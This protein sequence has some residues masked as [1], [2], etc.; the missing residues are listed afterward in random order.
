VTVGN[1]FFSPR[2]L[3]IEVGDT[4]RWTN[5][6][7][8]T[9]NVI[10]D[11]GAWRSETSSSFVFERTFNSVEEI[12]YYCSIH[13][14][15]NGSS[16]N[17]SISVI[18]ASGNEDPNA[19]FSF[20]CTGLTCVFT[21]Q[22]TD[23]DGT[24]VSRNWDFGDGGASTEANPSRSY[25]AGGT[26]SVKLTVMDNEGVSDDVS[27]DVTV[28]AANAAPTAAFSYSC[29][30]LDCDFTDQSMD[31]DGN[32]VAWSWSFGDSS[33][34][35]GARNP[36]HSYASAGT[37]AVSLRATDDDGDNDTTIQN[38]T[39]NS[40]LIN[41]GITDAWYFP[42]TG[43]QGF[44]IV[45]WEKISFMFLSWFTFDIGNPPAGMEDIPDKTIQR[46]LSARETDS[47]GN[48]LMAILGDDG[49]RWLTAQ[50]PYEG[51]TAMLEVFS[52][53]GGIFDTAPPE[54]VTEKTGT[55]KIQW[56]GC[57]SG[58]LTYDFP[59]LVLMGEILIERIV[60]D[61]VPMC[62]DAQAIQTD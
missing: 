41:P 10:E 44:F 12:E 4:V 32:I 39:V 37:Y 35:S 56:T 1:N 33:A 11:N 15:P 54:V 27:H 2:N 23:S 58:I 48:D 31:V 24:I 17:G 8:R 55:I 30:G 34:N 9:H 62:E 47:G 20:D 52:S 38:V 59:A 21:D 40:F 19:A 5:A 16:M 28:A 45:V 42:L 60:T 22:S 26:Y 25:A 46:M 13:S 14:S 29:T 3:T 57:N 43:G 36:S 6:S 18:E 51:D 49:Q 61:R 50:G 7:S 53:S